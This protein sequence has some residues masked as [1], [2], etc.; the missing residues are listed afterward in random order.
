[1]LIAYAKLKL[2]LFKIWQHMNLNKT[3]STVCLL[4]PKPQPYLLLTKLTKHNNI[5][6]YRVFG[7]LPSRDRIVDGKN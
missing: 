6:V 3:V 1:V 5:L 4:L 7:L 2:N